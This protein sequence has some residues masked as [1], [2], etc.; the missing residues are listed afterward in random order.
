MTMQTETPGI[1]RLLQLSGEGDRAAFAALFDTSAPS[2]YGFARALLTTQ[3]QAGEATVSVFTTLWEQAPHFNLDFTLDASDETARNRTA[4]TW[5]ISLA[6]RT[7]AELIHAGH[8]TE[9]NDEAGL[10][11]LAAELPELHGLSEAQLRA[12]T[13]IW[14][15]ARSY[16]EA[17]RELGVGVPT[18]KS[19]LRDTCSRLSQRYIAAVTGVS[20]TTQDPILAKPVTPEVTA[21]TGQSPTFSQSITTDLESGLVDELAALVAT[22]SI[23]EDER[24]AIDSHV[25]RLGR[26]KKEQWQLRISLLQRSLAWGFRRLTT[27]PESWMLD[28]LLESLP[29]Q[30]LGVGFV[31][32]FD[33]HEPEPEPA[34]GTKRKI[35][36]AVVIA[37]LL[38]A[39]IAI[40]TLLASS[41]DI[42]STVDD[43]HDTQ[44]TSPQDLNAGGTV[45]A[46]L[47]RDEDVAYLSF[48]SVPDLGADQTYQVWLFASAGDSP[49]SLG[50]YDATQ[51]EDRH[52]QFRGV[53]GYEQL[54]VTIEPENGSDYPTTEPLVQIDLH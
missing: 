20:D 44:L 3:E 39:V 50:Q 15:G 51:M 35:I 11:P 4:A 41:D 9:I 24:I 26:E 16:P 45:Q 32:Q 12:L 25:H 10:L 34:S 48:S 43:A 1:A 42:V 5:I 14:L 40:S 30:N 7:F 28:Q 18:L 6:Q 38:A 54:W 8:F 22:N 52:V 13:I 27:E 46:H 49:S 53:N 37:L 36:W 23:D 21:R 19:R 47:S 29:E 33:T 2:V 31:E 17:A